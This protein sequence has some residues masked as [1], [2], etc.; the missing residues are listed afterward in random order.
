[1]TGKNYIPS[2]EISEYVDSI[3]VIENNEVVETFTLPLFANGKPTLLFQTSKG[4][5]RNNSNYLTLF[6]QTIIPDQLTLTEN[7]ILIAY[8]FKPFALTTLFGFSAQ[9]LT[10]NPINLNLIQF[11]KANEL[12]EKLLNSKTVEQMI[13]ILDDFVFKLTA[14]IYTDN[15][16]ICYATKLIAEN[17]TKSVLKRAQDELYLTERTF[18]RMFEDKVGVSPN[19]YR[20]IAQF[21]CAFQQLNQ[22]QFKLFSDIA[23]NN[24]YADQSH[25][26]RAFKQFT[27]MTPKE[28]LNLSK[29]D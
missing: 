20:R 9:D 17:P 22:K 18:Q 29:S 3:L 5:I 4:T 1:M 11:Q 2:E 24:D 15:K 21:N 19:Q 13:S 23:F 12:K 14:K 27:N 16:L 28:Y 8:F 7:F 10:D 26:I 25:F 6:G